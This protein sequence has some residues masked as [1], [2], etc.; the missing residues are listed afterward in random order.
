MRSEAPPI[1]P[2]FRSQHQAELLSRLFLAGDEATMTDLARHLDIPLTTL[3]READRLERAGLLASRRVGRS[4][5]F[6]ANSRHPASGPLTELLTVAFGLARPPSKTIYR[7]R[8]SWRPR[9]EPDVFVPADLALLDGPVSGRHDPPVN[10]YWQPGELDFSDARDVRLFYSS[11]LT[12]ADT[13]EQFATWVN[14]RALKENW[15]AIALPS[16]V[17]AAWETLHPQLRG[18]SSPVNPRLRIQDEVLK[19]IA[20]Q[21]FALAGGSALIDFDVVTRDSEDIDAFLNRLDA[22]AFTQAAKSVIATCTQHSW[23]AEL[24]RDQD[25]DK[26]ILVGVP[27]DGKI[28]V[29]L[30]YHQR[31]TAP[32]PRAGGGLRLIFSDVVGGKAA[33]LAEVARGRDFD[34]I[35][36]VLDTRGWSLERVVDAMKTLGYPD[37]VD[38]FW[39]NIE[40]FRRGEF[41]DE[42]RKAGFDPAFSHRII[43]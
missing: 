28:V 34:D 14:A 43:G 18:G 30:V 40:R 35:A 20:A 26:Q 41:D 9:F 19:A 37:R 33:A 5:L 25:L 23:E 3:A 29:Q 21:G 13:A 31:S 12:K 7:L 15:S 1:L 6:R 42:I 10:L 38:G 2:I 27:G 16:R 11:A 4:R 39:R 32:E 22:E 24:I 36:H 17:R 8:P